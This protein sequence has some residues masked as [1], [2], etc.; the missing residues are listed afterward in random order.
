VELLT[1]TGLVALFI[2]ILPGYV[3]GRVKGWTTQTGQTGTSLA[4]GIYINVVRSL[5]LTIVAMTTAIPL[6]PAGLS[7][8]GSDASSQGAA[9]LLQ[10]PVE[11]SLLCLDLIVP[12]IAGIW[13]GIIENRRVMPRL[14]D[15]GWLKWFG[16]Q[17]STL[18]Q[19]WDTAFAKAADRSPVLLQ[20]ETKRGLSIFGL[21]GANS[22]ASTEG[23]YRD[24]FIEE[25]WEYTNG[26]LAPSKGRVSMLIRG[27][28]IST[29]RFITLGETP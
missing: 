15:W 5:F 9:V 13:I 22:A 2:L 21:F 3:Y 8:F 1:N 16:P 4:E 23:G 25:V 24:V 6:V 7:M 27:S 18:P 17:R 28:E 12:S 11:W 29:V 10:S 19:A 26:T 14:R 20:I